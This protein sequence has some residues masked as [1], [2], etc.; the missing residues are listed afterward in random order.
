MNDIKIK[1][2]NCFQDNNNR[3]TKIIISDNSK[4]T[5]IILEGNGSLKVAETV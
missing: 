4:D 3:K 5:E 1:E 2:I